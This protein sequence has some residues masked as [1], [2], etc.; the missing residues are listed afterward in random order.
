MGRVTALPRPMLA[1]LEA[2]TTDTQR[3]R[4]VWAPDGVLEFPYAPPDMTGRIE[5]VDALVAD[6]LSPR[7]LT[8]PATTPCPCPRRSPR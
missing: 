3:L 7:A 1:H 8:P 4:E 6:S 5:G 2:V